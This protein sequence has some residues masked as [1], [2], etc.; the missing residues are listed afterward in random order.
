M[1]QVR[2]ARVVSVVGVLPPFLTRLTRRHAAAEIV[3][4]LPVLA[5]LLVAV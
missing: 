3:R 5:L 2:H 4:F 1:G